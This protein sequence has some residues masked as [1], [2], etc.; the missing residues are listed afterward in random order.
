MVTNLTVVLL[1]YLVGSFPTGIVFGRV[2][3]GI[4]VRKYGSGGMGAANVFRVLGPKVA[5]PVLA[6]DILKGVVATV[7]ISRVNLGDLTIPSHWLQLIAGLAAIIGHVFP[8]WVGFKGGKGVGTGAGVILGLMP[9]ETAFAV[10]L[11]AIVVALT[12]YVSLGSMLAAA[13]LPFALLVEKLCLGLDIPH[14]YVVLTLLLTVIVIVTH[15]QN[16][17]RL[18][19]GEE[20]KLGQKAA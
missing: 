4:D 2:F 18:T 1:S 12:K 5:V 16:I 10:L 6:V 17:L 15:R 11:F 14:A 19:R 3:K 7:F 13:F 8:V 20:N 9:L